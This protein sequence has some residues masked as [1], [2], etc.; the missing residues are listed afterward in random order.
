MLR[1]HRFLETPLKGNLQQRIPGE[2]DG[3]PLPMDALK[4][5]EANCRDS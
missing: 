3:A 1:K 2:K 4:N 5:V